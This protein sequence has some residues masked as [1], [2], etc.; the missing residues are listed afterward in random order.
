MEIK[1]EVEKIWNS[2]LEKWDKKVTYEIR[3]KNST[4]YPGILLSGFILALSI[5][6]AIYCLSPLDGDGVATSIFFMLLSGLLCKQR[7]FLFLSK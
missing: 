4:N 6:S 5:I 1:K 2:K 3:R 7:A